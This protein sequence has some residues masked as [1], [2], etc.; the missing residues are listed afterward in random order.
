MLVRASCGAHENQL[1]YDAAGRLIGE[2]ADGQSLAFHYSPNGTRTGIVPSIGARIDFAYFAD[3]SLQSI[4]ADGRSLVRYARN[5]QGQLTQAAFANGIVEKHAWDPCD[6]LSDWELGRPHEPP[7]RRRSFGYDA[8]SQLTSVADAQRGTDR[9]NYTPHGWVERQLLAGDSHGEEFRFDAQ[10]NFLNLPGGRQA[11]YAAGDR[12]LDDGEFTYEYDELGRTAARVSRT[13]E[14]TAYGYD[15][16]DL[17][18]RLERADGRV[19]EYEYDA[20][21]RRVA[22]R[23]GEVTTQYLWDGDQLLASWTSQ[24]AVQQYVMDPYRWTPV[25]QL[26]LAQSGA[27]VEPIVQFCHADHL[28]CVTEL[29]SGAGQVIWSVQYD[30]LGKARQLV[31]TAEQ[32]PLRRPGQYYDAE[33]GWY[34]NRFRYYDPDTARF[35]TP[36]PIDV[37]GGPNL[38]RYPGSAVTTLDLLGL[39]PTALVDNNFLVSL[40]AAENSG[41]KKSLEHRLAKSERLGVSPTAYKEF[42]E[43]PG[44]SKQERQRRR[45]LLKKYKIEPVELAC[46]AEQ[47]V[48]NE[49]FRRYRQQGLDVNDSAIAAHSRAKGLP[50]YSENTMDFG[51]RMGSP[52]FRGDRFPQ[53]YA[54]RVARQESVGMASRGAEMFKWTFR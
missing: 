17:M 41:M 14:R 16:R 42:T 25:A 49:A 3:G 8:D 6:R 37:D 24:G 32:T 20:F 26:D 5:D 33:T 38:Y 19:V 40:E 50:L 4:A 34:Y 22:K 43:A 10:G 46:A 30:A 12:L 36:D 9:F 51:G 1:E 47:N 29:T 21:G 44:F 18:T 52:G 28:G 11:K 27:S 53:S 31:G 2:T 48:F 54:Q 13:G 35:T 15:F 45:Q 23:D 39:F 7:S